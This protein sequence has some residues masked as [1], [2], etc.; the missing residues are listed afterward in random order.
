[1]VAGGFDLALK[2]NYSNEGIV[3]GPDSHPS[4]FP[5]ATLFEEWA[6]EIS[7]K[8]RPSPTGKVYPILLDLQQTHCEIEE[9]TESR[10]IFQSAE[11]T[12]NC[13]LSLLRKGFEN[14]YIVVVTP[15]RH[16][17]KLL[18]EVLREAGLVATIV[19]KNEI[20]LA[21]V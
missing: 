8:T 11:L 1:M 15:Y 20:L 19:L 13:I 10:K 9:G 21:T 18:K 2:V 7:K 4:N 16:D 14:R 3:D 6:C 12:V 5:L 17:L